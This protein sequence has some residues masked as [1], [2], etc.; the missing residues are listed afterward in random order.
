MPSMKR[1]STIARRI[2]VATL[3]L[4]STAAVPQGATRYT[5]EIVVY[6]TASQVGALPGAAVAAPAMPADDGVEATAATTRKLNAAAN[7]LRASA[8]F[9]VLAHTAWTQA[10]TSCSRDAC[11]SSQRGVSAMQAGLARAGISGKVILQRGSN[12]FLGVDL[13]IEDG[14]RRYHIQ[15][16]RQTKADQTQYFD[17]PAV[18]VL[19]VFTAASP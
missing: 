9:R 6:R 14:G 11:R 10:P 19:A 8:G 7:R 5:V 4:A 16:V 15:E 2:A 3:L 17:H 13:V 1:L 18:G 12:L